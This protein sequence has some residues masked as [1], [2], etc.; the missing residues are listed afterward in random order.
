MPVELID[1]HAHLDENAFDTDRDEVVARCG[2]AGLAAVLTI[3][4][5][6]A[7]SQAAV[8]LAGR[9][10][11]VHAVVGI[12]PNYAA[13][14]KPEDW[15][16]IVA[17][18]A[19]PTVVAI[20]ET[21]LDRYWDYAPI[22]LQVEYFRK[23]MQLARERALPFVVHCR[24]AE[25]DVVAELRLAA[26]AGPLRGVMHSFCGDAATAEQCLELGLYI[27]ISGMVT[28][29]KNDELRAVASSCADFVVG[30]FDC[31]EVD[32]TVFSVMRAGNDRGV[33]FG[34]FSGQRRGGLACLIGV[35]C[36]PCARKRAT[37]GVGIHRQCQP[38]N[39]AELVENLL[40]F[41]ILLDG[42]SGHILPHAV[43]ECRHR[44][45]DRFFT[46]FHRPADAAILQIN[47]IDEFLPPSNDAARCRAEILVRAGDD[48]IAPVIDQ[49]LQ[50]L[51]LRRTVDDHR[52]ARV[53]GQLCEFRKS[54]PAVAHRVMRFDGNHRRDGRRIERIPE[55]IGQTAIHTADFDRRRTGKSYRLRDRRTVI[56][57]VPFL[58][59]DTRGHSVGFGQPQHAGKIGG[60]V[61]D[62]SQNLR[63]TRDIA[64]ADGTILAVAE[65]LG[66]INPTITIDA[67]GQYV[68]PGLI[69][70]HVHVYPHHGPYG[71]EPDPL[72]PAGGVTT[73]LDAGSAGSY[74]FAGFRKHVID[75]ADTEVLALVNLS[76][77]GL[78]AANLGELL[79]RRYADVEGV[80]STIR[81]NPGVAV[82]VKIRAGR[83]IIGEGETGWA[84]FRDAIAAA[85]ESGTWLMVHIGESPMPI[86]EMLEHFAPGDCITHC[87][88][89]GSE[90]ILDPG[91]RLFDAVREAADRGVIFDVGHGFGSFQWETVEAAIEQGFEPTTISTDLHT[92]N[93]H[94][95]VYDMPTTMSKFLLLGVPLERVIE[96]STTRPAAAL[97]RS[98]DLGTLR[99]GTTADVAV[100]ER[101]QGEFLFTDSYRQTRSGR[102]LL[103][104]ACTIR[105]GEIV[106][107]GG[108]T[109]MR[110][111]GQ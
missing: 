39:V 35:G 7:N 6:A 80:L 14:A 75:R 62:P 38:R 76:C 106:P 44:P 92:K 96:M 97:N 63:G 91:G 102:E 90:R 69:D 78:T 28:Y 20:G 86:P 26:E 49:L 67:R 84:N 61:I 94:G 104:A 8:D 24:D 2:E 55:F 21:G 40:N 22:E 50:P 23:H 87:F 71:L 10:E 25:P 99:V 82:G 68:V 79:D 88:K 108:G 103:T 46:G 43:L 93:L 64:I 1:T 5:T 37:V 66:D 29:K 42:P 32:V 110:T 107:G 111:S 11:S 13:E 19:N 60:E 27:S 16:S 59:D 72:C 18:S 98:D 73:M 15:E 41:A 74:N 3:G 105:K 47:R 83:H 81:A 100:L 77:I 51:V 48:E 9:Y 53:V 101:H 31:V 89:G 4:T 65:S 52:N 95:P 33:A 12:Q 70:L 36:Q 54:H 30:H 17:L 85:R 57:T 56:H 45:D 58:N 34:Q 109:R